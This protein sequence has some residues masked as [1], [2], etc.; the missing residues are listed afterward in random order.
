ME[1]IGRQKKSLVDTE[2]T[3]CYANS[4]VAIQIQRSLCL[5]Q[6]WKVRGR[7]EESVGALGVIGRQKKSL[8]CNGSHWLLCKITGC[9]A[10]PAV[11]MERL[12]LLW[13]VR[14]RYEETVGAMKVIGR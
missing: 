2:V 7:Y 5:R 4:L 1:V 3:G 14:G 10:K 13:K 8:V 12:R 6:L 11:A 9:Y